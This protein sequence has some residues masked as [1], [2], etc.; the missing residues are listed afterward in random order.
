MQRK[1]FCCFFFCLFLALNIHAKNNSVLF[2]KEKMFLTQINDIYF[3]FDDYKD[4]TIVV[5][6]MFG[7]LT[8]FDKSETWAVVYRR[9]PGCCGN[10]GWG[11]FLLQ[12]ENNSIKEK[13]K[14][15]AEDDWICVKGKPKL[16]ENDYGFIDLYLVVSNIEV[17]T[18]R[19]AEF[20]MQ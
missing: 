16:V 11:G 19:G 1:I 14:S 7:H 4:K 18:K 20:V 15:L 6:G 12:G 5:E 17:K 9:G 10:D 3:N 8:S 13:I 2:I